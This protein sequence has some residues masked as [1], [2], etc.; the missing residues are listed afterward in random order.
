MV[1]LRDLKREDIILFKKWLCTPHVARWY[2]DPEDWIEELEKQDD[3]FNWIHHYIVE[4][5]E[6]PVGFCQYY[7]CKDSDEMWEGYTALG[8]S[9][10]ID[11]M[12]GETNYLYMG[13]GKKIV[14]DLINKISLHSDAKRIVVQPE[15]E[16]K[17][18]C[19]LLESCGFAFDE[20]TRIYV[21]NLG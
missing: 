5:G 3:E 20:K 11:Y 21:K 10:S 14:A 15:Q 13:L 8:G 17:A 12:I 19:G 6:K 4:Y 2:R 16:N 9:Y 7:A 1:Y 18:S